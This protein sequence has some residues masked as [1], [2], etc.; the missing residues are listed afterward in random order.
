MTSEVFF[1]G[2]KVT[3]IGMGIVFVALYLM[4]LLLLALGF[5]A[6][7]ATKESKTAHV[8]S[9]ETANHV[10]TVEVV[11][12]AVTLVQPT[13]EVTYGVMIAI[14]AALAA[15]MGSRPVNI[16]SIRKDHIAVS[17]WQ[18]AS[19]SGNAERHHN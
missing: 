1:Y 14:S 15:A 12:E 8:V 18:Q 16:V 5:V 11:D 4:Q 19:R 2:L 6:G 9:T 7:A 17:S 13:Q 10:E 3:A